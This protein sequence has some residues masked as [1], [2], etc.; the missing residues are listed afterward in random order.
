MAEK[1]RRALAVRSIVTPSGIQ[2]RE[3]VPALGAGSGLRLRLGPRAC[4][5]PSGLHVRPGLSPKPVP[6][7]V[8][9]EPRKSRTSLS[10]AR[11]CRL[12]L[13]GG[14][15]VSSPKTKGGPAAPPAW[16]K[17]SLQN[18]SATRLRPCPSERAHRG[19]SSDA[20]CPCVPLQSPLSPR[21]P[22]CWCPGHRMDSGSL[23][24]RPL[25]PLLQALPCYG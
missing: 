24:S 3:P 21:R 20:S 17:G 16:G 8:A 23:H 10:T 14:P 15:G 18:T 2:Q 1:Q 11:G 13:E 22:C 7:S 5:A 6:G 19:R 25:Q 4:P 12:V 9:R